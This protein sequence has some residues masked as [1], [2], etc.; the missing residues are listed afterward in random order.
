MLNLI[1][2]GYTE[3]GYIAPVPRLHSGIRFKFRPMLHEVKTALLVG[4]ERK[5]PAQ[6]S[7][8]VSEAV[9][10]HVTEWDVTDANGAAAPITLASV[11]HLRPALV[12]DLYNIVSGW[13]ASDPDPDATDAD[14]EREA[15]AE[16]TSLLEG[17]SP[18]EVKEENDRKN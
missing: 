10:K 8:I 9:A 6:R 17:K 7:R 11:Q 13:K 3:A 15:D 1:P 16:L 12:D 2:D 5:T 14:A 4:M 18:G